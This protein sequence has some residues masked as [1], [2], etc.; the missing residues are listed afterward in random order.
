MAGCKRNRGYKEQVYGYKEEI[1]VRPVS[2]KNRKYDILS[3][4]DLSVKA[5]NNTLHGRLPQ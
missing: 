1:W 4:L 2:Y 3:I 5:H